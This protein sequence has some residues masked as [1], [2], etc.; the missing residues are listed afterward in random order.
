ME[1]VRTQSVIQFFKYSFCVCISFAFALLYMLYLQRPANNIAFVNSV[2]LLEGYKGMQQARQVYDQKAAVWQANIDTLTFEVEKALNKVKEK[3]L[4][5]EELSLAAQVLSLKQ[6]Q[7]A[8]YKKAIAEQSQREDQ[9]LSQEVIA[10][11]NSFLMQYG[12]THHYQAIIASTP[13]N[14]L[15]YTEESI[16]ITEEVLQALN[17]AYR[18]HNF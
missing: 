3:G 17:K 1:R 15:N 6:E 18:Q 8:Q 2:K 12:K 7:L 9:Q 5:T 16:D 14:P 4:S 11:T 13:D 10:K